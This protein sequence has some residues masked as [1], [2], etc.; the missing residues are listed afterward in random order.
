MTD[1]VIVGWRR[2]AVLRCISSIV[3]HSNGEVR[4]ILVCNNKKLAKELDSWSE[5]EESVAVVPEGGN[6]GW[7]VGANMGL[8]VSESPYVVLMNDDCEVLTDGWLGKLQAPFT[9]NP[10]IPIACVARWGGRGFQ[11][12]LDKNVG[13]SFH[14]PKLS[15]DG[16]GIGDFPISFFCVMFSREAL[17]AVGCLDERFSPG[18][19]DDDDWLARAHLSG[20]K[21]GIQTDVQ[22]KH[23]SGG[24]DGQRGEIQKRNVRLL[25]EKY[26][27]ILD[28]QK[29]TLII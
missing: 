11:G 18:Y 9:M 10:A 3:E 5:L 4:I 8:A 12:R 23:E 22:V 21:M 20:W 6:V 16:F 15:L 1:V 29:E 19:G 24:Y 25:R 17:D 14:E 28:K 26:A 7:V 2:D 27:N 13:S